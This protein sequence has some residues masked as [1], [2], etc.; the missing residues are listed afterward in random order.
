VDSFRIIVSVLHGIFS[1]H[2]DWVAVDSM[3]TGKDVRNT[4]DGIFVLVVFCYIATAAISFVSGI[5]C[6]WMWGLLR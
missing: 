1:D 3:I 2:S 5:V 4:I 6:S